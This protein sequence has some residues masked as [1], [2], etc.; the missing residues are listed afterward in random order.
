[1]KP[2]FQSADS[3]INLDTAH[4]VPINPFD[5]WYSALWLHQNKLWIIII[6]NHELQ[7]D[8]LYTDQI[9]YDN[10]SSNKQQILKIHQMDLVVMDT[11][12]TEG[13]EDKEHRIE[14]ELNTYSQHSLYIPLSH[15]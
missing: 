13:K 12:D 4:G 9:D 2:Y 3:A 14:E 10:S 7:C 6:N 5:V 15:N 1:M 8:S 11:T